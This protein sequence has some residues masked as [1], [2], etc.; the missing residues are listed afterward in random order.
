MAVLSTIQRIF[1]PPRFVTLPSVGIDISDTTLKYIQFKRK[2]SRDTTME[3]ECW[4]D[5]DIPAGVLERGNVH[6]LRELTKVLEEVKKAT[7]ADYIRV[8]LPEER[9]YLFEVTLDNDVSYKE[10]RGLLEFKL[11]EN[12]PLS[13]SEVYFDYDIVSVTQKHIRVVVAVYA[14]ET[15][16]NYYDACCEAG[17]I[18]LS[19]EIE[20]QAIARA[21]IRTG[22]TGTYMVIDFGKTRMG[23]GIVHEGILMYTST[24]DIGGNMMSQKMRERLGDTAESEL[25]KIK[26]TKGIIHSADNEDVYEALKG[27]IATMTEEIETRVH[28]WDTRDDDHEAR[29][30]EKIVLCGGSAN[31]AGLPEYLSQ[32]FAIPAERARVWQNAFSLSDFVPPITRRYSYGYATAIGL[33]LGDFVRVD[34]D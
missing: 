13:P 9:A 10:I 32:T 30:I 7:T 28:Y 21:A 31:L 17:L 29:Q 8:S 33:A 1:P 22:L 2:H 26:N 14:K 5:M 23:V 25:T 20:A 19:F 3:L 12:V 18:P 15:I 6:K 11:E 4:G 34:H 27:V 16:N 24:I